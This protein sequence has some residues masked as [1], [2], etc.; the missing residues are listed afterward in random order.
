M[1]QTMAQSL[2]TGPGLSPHGGVDL[3]DLATYGMLSYLSH[4]KEGFNK[5]T[6]LPSQD[7]LR[8]SA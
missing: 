7:W 3:C 5:H 2:H 8:A 1:H 6:R 4:I